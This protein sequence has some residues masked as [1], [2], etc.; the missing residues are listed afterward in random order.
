[1]VRALVFALCCLCAGVA[2]ADT[3]HV[4]TTELRI[5]DLRHQSAQALIPVLRPML[6]PDGA[7]SGQG[8]QL[9]VRDRPEYLAQIAKAVADLDVPAQQLRIHVHYAARGESPPG[10][11]GTEIVHHYG[12]RTEISDQFVTV[13][14][15]HTAFVQA[16][17]D[18]PDVR[19]FLE[20]AGNQAMVLPDV[21][22]RSITT[23]FA[24]IPH[25]HQDQVELEVTPQLA[26]DT[27]RGEQTVVFH[28]L[29]TRVRAPLGKW[30]ELGG[31]RE[32]PDN[33]VGREILRHWG[34][35]APQ[36]R[37]M[38]LKVEKAAP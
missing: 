28:R 4:D 37:S 31:S 12:T 23:G 14:D 27:E 1:M 3:L 22:Y 18:L 25:V 21:R 13:L 7:I 16:G 33:T 8:D 29:V 32:Q 35:Q 30:I 38:W 2:F 24:V 9:L 5:F 10:S 6:S 15:G 36:T 26:F 19:Y 17:R 34:T 20:L 11:P